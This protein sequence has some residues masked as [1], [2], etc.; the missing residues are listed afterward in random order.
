MDRL[1]KLLTAITYFTMVSQPCVLGTFFQTIITVIYS[2]YTLYW[3]EIRIDEIN[4]D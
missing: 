4:N 3:K 2:G 1:D